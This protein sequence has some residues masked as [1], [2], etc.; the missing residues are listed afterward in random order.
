M[1][2]PR[3]FDEQAVLTAARARFWRDGYAATSIQDLTEATG[4]GTQ[5][6]YGAFGN[7]HK[8]FLRILDEYG[9]RQATGLEA[10]ITADPSPW[11]GLLAAVTFEEGGRLDLPPQ[12]C[13]MANSASALSAQDEQVRDRS[14]RAYSRTLALFTRQVT[15]AQEAGEI[16]HGIDPEATARTLFTVMQGIEFL[17]KAGIGDEELRR[18]KT[19]AVEMI[20][21]SVGH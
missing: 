16:D 15:R 17:H 11:H 8:L 4:L 1:P 21:R 14:C 2:R 7:K 12:G 6:L 20:E 10:A 3:K 13:L 5:S 9:T 18:A 19:A